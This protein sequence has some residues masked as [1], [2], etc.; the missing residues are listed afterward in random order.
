MYPFL[1]TNKSLYWL[2][3]ERQLVG[4]NS[5]PK[6]P[7]QLQWISC[8][9]LVLFSVGVITNVLPAIT[10]LLKFIV[11]TPVSAATETPP[12]GTYFPRKPF[13]AEPIGPV[14]ATIVAS[15]NALISAAI[16]AISSRNPLVSL[17]P[18]VACAL[19]VYWLYAG[20]AIAANTP[21]IVITIISSISVKPLFFLICIINSFYYKTP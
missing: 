11:I 12:A 16:A 1:K 21:I 9:L 19:P 5:S 7:P 14:V 4:K 20:K 17:I 15:G 2:N 6:V 3:Y 18:S 10:P 8:V 13:A